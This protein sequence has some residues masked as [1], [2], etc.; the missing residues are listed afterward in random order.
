MIDLQQR[1]VAEQW[2]FIRNEESQVVVDTV[3]ELEI[4]RTQAERTTGR[5]IEE[6]GSTMATKMGLAF[7]ELLSTGCEER[8]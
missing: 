8:K 4:L 1:T 3:A 5:D 7:Q 2:K 6:V